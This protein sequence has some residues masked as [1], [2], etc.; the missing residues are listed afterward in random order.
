MAW[1][2]EAPGGDMPYLLAYTLG[3]APAGPGAAS[4]ALRH[5][6]ESNGLPV[7]GDLVDGNGRPDLP[8]SML[9]RAGQAVVGMPGFNAQCIPPPEW[10]AAVAARGYAYFLFTTRP[11]PE[12]LP[13]KPLEPEALAAFVGADETLNTAA[14]IILPAHGPRG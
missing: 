13:G 4:A 12:A 8:V 10:L 2:G 9:V 14:H 6:L 7:G 11:W 5:M 1:S 3:D